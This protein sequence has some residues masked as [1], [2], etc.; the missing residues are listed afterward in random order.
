MEYSTY[1]DL[2]DDRC[3]FS[4][5]DQTCV[6]AAWHEE[7]HRMLPRTWI[8]RTNTRLDVTMSRIEESHEKRSC[9]PSL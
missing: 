2:P 4:R 6:R 1:T 3:G 8:R 7:P 5:E 9:N